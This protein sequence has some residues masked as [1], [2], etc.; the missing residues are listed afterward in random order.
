MPP[1]KTASAP[2]SLP[3]STNGLAAVTSHRPAAMPVPD[4]AKVAI[5][6]LEHGLNESPE[7]SR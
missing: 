4:L 7:T 3:G 1:A 2:P 5:S 6:M